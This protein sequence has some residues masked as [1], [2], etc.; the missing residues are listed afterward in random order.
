MP[1]T[2]KR[3]LRQ[4]WREAVAF[5]AGDSAE[6]LLL[7]FDLMLRE[8][9][10]EGEA[11]YRVLESAGLLWLADEPGAAQPTIAP[12]GELPAV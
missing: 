12:D 1:L 10:D 2:A 6:L 7:R 3:K 4:T 11:A 5:R 8:G 9:R